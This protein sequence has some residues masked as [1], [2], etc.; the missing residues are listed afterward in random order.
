VQELQRRET[1]GTGFGG[2]RG[3]KSRSWLF[4]AVVA[5]TTFVVFLP[6]LRGEFLMWDDDIN[7]Y[8][9]PH[10]RGVNA[11]NLRWMFTDLQQA[12][13]YKPLCWLTWALIYQIR[14]F[15]PVAYHL[16]NLLFHTTNA[17]LVFFLLRKLFR[18][19]TG[20]APGS[21]GFRLLG[22][23]LGALLWSLHPL[24]VEPVAWATGLPY[25]QSLFFLLISLLAYLKGFE[26]QSGSAARVGW[27]L[28]SLAGFGAALFTY[29]TVLAYLGML[30]CLD[31]YPLRRVR[32]ERGAAWRWSLAELIWEKLPF[33]GITVLLA[34]A[35]L[36]ARYHAHGTW[37]PPLSLDQ[38]GAGPRL[39]QAFYVWGHYLWKLCWPLN[40]HPYYT[41][42]IDFQPPVVFWVAA[43]A[44]VCL[45]IV[46]WQRR[47]QWPAV[48]SIWVCYLVML[49]PSLGLTEYPHVASDRYVFVASIGWSALVVLAL[50]RTGNRSWLRAPA[51]LGLGALLAAYAVLTFRQIAVWRNTTALM[52]HTIREL[53]DSPY[54]YDLYLRLGKYY[55]QT[56]EFSRARDSLE[57]AVRIHPD[58]P[59][60]HEGLGEMLL[61]LGEWSR[62]ADEFAR[63]IDLEPQELRPHFYLALAVAGQG[64]VDEAKE[65][66]SMIQQ[67][68]GNQVP[69]D[70]HARYLQAIARGYARLYRTNEALNAIREAL[71]FARMSGQVELVDRLERQ[72][73]EYSAAN[74]SQE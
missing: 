4:A 3:L 23:A 50:M 61:E 68:M 32:A 45:T 71:D 22:C 54:R 6:V 11:P 1:N 56:A 74:P 43:F 30:I 70:I 26:P 41:T 21:E 31:L 5:V 48:L 42:L 17:A 10:V 67:Q 33:V 52:E 57:Q 65:Q 34:A 46:F 29:P 49:I 2:D 60:A 53:G 59:V 51:V 44:V 69:A 37:R 63:A 14:G 64:K 8:E 24:R 27:W 18:F 28:A 40:L 72:R 39:M 25:G 15:E 19:S 35:T 47:K 7:I 13:R 58:Q 62:A 38:F 66:F 55:K 12:L 20:A 36:I 16:V 9:N 73:Q